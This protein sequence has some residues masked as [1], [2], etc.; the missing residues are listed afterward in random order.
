MRKLGTLVGVLAAV[1]LL[2]VREVPAYDSKTYPGSVCKARDADHQGDLYY[3]NGI[4]ENESSGNLT[5]TCPILR[6]FDCLTDFEVIVK[7]YGNPD[8]VSCTL[9]TGSSTGVY[10]SATEV[11]PGSAENRTLSWPANPVSCSSSVVYYVNC[12]LPAETVNGARS[13]VNRIWAPEE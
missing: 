5:V 1:S 10:D 9:Y 4:A 13:A 11:S 7:D 12:L 3:L 6:D 8:R 2:D